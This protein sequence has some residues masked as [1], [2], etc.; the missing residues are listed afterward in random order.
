MLLIVRSIFSATERMNLHVFVQ[1]ALFGT[2]IL[3]LVHMDLN[4]TVVSDYFYISFI[5][6]FIHSST[7][8]GQVCV[9]VLYLITLLYYE[10]KVYT[11]M[12]NNS[13]NINTTHLTSTHGT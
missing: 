7:Q 1:S 9:L 13:S 4:R 6:S 3:S 2:R 8:S 12:I 10:K 11:V 5:H